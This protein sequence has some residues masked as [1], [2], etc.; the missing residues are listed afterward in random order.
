[1]IFFIAYINYSLLTTVL[2]RTGVIRRPKSSITIILHEKPTS[3][4][5][6]EA[7]EGK[8]PPG[9]GEI[10]R[11]RLYESNANFD[12]LRR[13]SFMLSSSGRS[14]RREQFKRLVMLTKKDLQRRGIFMRDRQIAKFMLE[15]SVQVI[16]AKKE[17]QAQKEMREL[18][19]DRQLHFERNYD[20]KK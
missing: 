6:R 17:E 12:D 13:Y 7:L 18:N 9:V 16:M 20:K 3:H 8:S 10:F 14:Y 4:M 11:R 5:I 1:M 2:G 15:K 19:L